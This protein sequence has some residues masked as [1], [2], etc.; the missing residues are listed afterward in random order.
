MGA[1]P[2][3]NP[4]T[5]PNPDPNPKPDPNPNPKP[6]RLDELAAHDVGEHA[7]D[8]DAREELRHLEGRG[9]G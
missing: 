6:E 3:P 2:N 7:G 8:R 5:D 9:A 4:N 1:N